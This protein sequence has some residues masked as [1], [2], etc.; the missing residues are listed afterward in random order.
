MGLDQAPPAAAA[1]ASSLAPGFRFHPTDQELVGFY[2][3]RKV[4]GKPF[5][6]DPISVIDIYKCEPWD[7]PGKSRLKSRDLEWYFFSALDKKYGKVTGRT[8][9]ATEKGYWKTT[10]KD[11][12]IRYKSRT[13][14]MK[15]TLVYHCGRAPKGE[16]TNWVMHEYK[17]V[18][19]EFEKTGNV[20]CQRKLGFIFSVCVNVE[21]VLDVNKIEIKRSTILNIAQENKTLCHE[22]MIG[23]LML[24]FCVFVFWVEKDAMVLCRVFRKSGTGPKNGEQYGAP[25]DEEEW[26]DELVLVPGQDDMEGAAGG[27]DAYLDGNDLEQILGADISS[28]DVPLPLSFYYEDSSSHF[29]EPLV[30]DNDNQKLLVDVGENYSAP[31]QPD[32]Q[33][34]FDL[35]VQ[36]DMYT[37]PVRYEYIGEPSHS[38]NSEDA[39]YLLDDPFLDATDNPPF[40]EGAFLEANDLSNSVK[41]ESS[42]FDILEDY[43]TF[44]DSDENENLVS[45]QASLAQKCA[46]GGAPQETMGSQ[47]LTQGNYNDVASTSKQEPGNFGSDIQYPFLNKASCMLESISAPPAFASD[48]P[49]KDAT[50]LRLS[51]TAHSS[52]SIHVTAGI[53]RIRN[54]T[55]GGNGTYWSLGKDVDVNIVISFG[56]SHNDASLEPKSGSGMSWGWLY[57]LFLWVLIISMS[58]KIG[59]YMYTGKA[60]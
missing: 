10:G 25:F 42:G 43:L 51:S 41:V 56:L 31:E 30:S 45:D 8:N 19:E 57:L 3:R 28:E 22:L 44:F 12:P 26:D 52:N 40:D 39:D 23:V 38:V 14:G 53:I 16:R 17:L 36:N 1:S 47:Q 34:L 37:N 11:R 33:N 60:S 18:D 7:L 15:K 55:S 32:G 58:F 21:L 6:F 46:N 20:Q 13:V 50:A 2:L 48:F 27:D 24:F 4:F 54:M 29:Q 35:P 49:S 59:S 9:R 5:R